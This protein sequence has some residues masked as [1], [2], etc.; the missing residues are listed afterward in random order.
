[1]IYEAESGD[2]T[3]VAS[4]DTMITRRL[5]VFREPS[6]VSLVDLF[7]QA[8]VGYTNL[9]MLIQSTSTPRD[10]REAPTRPRNL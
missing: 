5:S 10:A 4:G 6:F 1:M 9:E 7:R 8:D 2:L 3:V